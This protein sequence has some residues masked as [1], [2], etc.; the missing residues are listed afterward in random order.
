MKN[1]IKKWLIGDQ[2]ADLKIKCGLAKGLTM[3]LNPSVE[4]KRVYGFYELEIAAQFRKMAKGARYFFDIGAAAGYYS[5][6]FRK[7]N[8]DG[9]IIMFEPGV[10]KF[11]SL[12][13]H[14]FE[15]S[16]FT[17]DNVERSDKMVG[18]A[19]SDDMVSIDAYIALNS[20][21]VFFKIDVDGGELDVLKSAERTLRGNDCRLIVETHS[22][23]LEDECVNYLRS[24]GY[25]VKIIKNGWYRFLIKDLREL[26]MNRWFAAW[27]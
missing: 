22:Y 12:Q 20:E 1:R 16:G 21:P 5:L 11:R 24:L 23:N 18:T 2:I 7:L 3:K 10:S 9:Q 14:N 13:A 25:T 4:L 17:L 19:Q 15:S 27:K 8:K 26:E 6:I